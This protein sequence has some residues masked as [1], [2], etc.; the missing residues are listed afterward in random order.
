MPSLDSPSQPKQLTLLPLCSVIIAIEKYEFMQ[1]CVCNCFQNN[2]YCHAI[3]VFKTIGKVYKTLMLNE[4]SAVAV[5]PGL[6]EGGVAAPGASQNTCFDL[7]C[8][9]SHNPHTL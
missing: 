4:C 6:F 3:I 9:G 2:N 5:V 7:C 8:T 1:E